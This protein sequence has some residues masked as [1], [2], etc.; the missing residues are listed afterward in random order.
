MYFHNILYAEYFCKGFLSTGDDAAPGN[1]ALK[2]QVEALR[3]VQKNIAAFGGDPNRVTIFGE[4]AGGMSVHFHVLSSLSKGLF[5]RAISESG[6]ALMPLFFRT[7]GILSQAQ[8][9]AEAVG[10]PTQNSDELVSCLRTLDIDTIMK[11]QPSDVSMH[12]ALVRIIGL[13]S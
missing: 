8:R 9:L 10:C 4:S 11:N 5:H 3:W 1:F 12:C 2:D 7:N 6:S 13:N